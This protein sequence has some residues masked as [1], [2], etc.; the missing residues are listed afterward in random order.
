M[1]VLD[2][3]GHAGRAL[4]RCGLAKSLAAEERGVPPSVAHRARPVLTSPCEP[5]HAH[6]MSMT[7]P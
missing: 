1:G 5:L 2:A 6:D 3:P 4:K 7:C